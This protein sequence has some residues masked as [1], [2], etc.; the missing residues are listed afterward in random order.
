MKKSQELLKNAGILPKLQLATKEEG[1]A[2][3]STG[4]HTVTFLSEKIV[5]G[6]S[7][8]GNAIDI[9]HYIVEE[10]GIKKYYPIPIK[11]STGEL[12]YRIQRLAEVPED[13]EVTLEVKRGKNG[14]NF[15][16]I[17]YEKESTI[18]EEVPTIQVGEDD[19][20]DGNTEQD[21]SDDEVPF[22]ED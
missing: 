6:K 19:R 15:T 2:P 18:S 21:K 4:S 8:E 22:E 3:V 16:Q 9:M 12:D 17:I 13:S 11:N 1:K 5:K 14:K 20:L 10:D 7:F